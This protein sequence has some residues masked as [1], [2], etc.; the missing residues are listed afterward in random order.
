MLRL[1]RLDILSRDAF[2]LAPMALIGTQR[3]LREGIAA[4]TGPGPLAL[5]ARL[6]LDMR[7]DIG[8]RSPLKAR[9]EFCQRVGAEIH[10]GAFSKRVARYFLR[11]WRAATSHFDGSA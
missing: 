10:A 9:A 6:H 2:D 7:R 1:E 8:D 3:A 5:S 4:L 11:S